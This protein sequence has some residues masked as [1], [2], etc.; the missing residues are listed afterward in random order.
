M[1]VPR[2][3]LDSIA[4]IDLSYP[5]GFGAS[6]NPIG[7][8][9]TRR[10]FSPNHHRNIEISSVIL[11]LN[12]V[13]LLLEPEIPLQVVSE[14]AQFVSSKDFFLIVC[15]SIDV[16]EEQDRCIEHFRHRIKR[17]DVENERGL[18]EGI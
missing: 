14:D 3:C 12:Q 18:N 5:R 17:E 10:S 11:E 4:S 2:S 7:R 16:A 6:Q 8:A 13:V 1:I 15:P 9:R